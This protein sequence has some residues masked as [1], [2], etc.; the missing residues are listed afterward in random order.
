MAAAAATGG[1][2]RGEAEQLS[3]EALRERSLGAGRPPGSGQELG[4]VVKMVPENVQAIL[5]VLAGV[6]DVAVP[7]LVHVALRVRIRFGVRQAKG[8]ERLV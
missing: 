5:L 2:L 1:E 6:Q 7:H 8:K 4:G 3:E